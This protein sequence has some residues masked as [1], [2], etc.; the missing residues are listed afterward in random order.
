VL[1]AD[2]DWFE[3]AGFKAG[4]PLA[5]TQKDSKAETPPVD[6]ADTYALTRELPNKRRGGGWSV[7]L[8]RRGKKIVRLFKDSIYGSPEAAYTQARAYRDAVISALPPLTNLEQAVKIRKNNQSGISGVRRVETEEGDAWQATLMT[9][10][11]QKKET[12]S[13]GRLGEEAARS[14]AITQRTRWLKSLPIKH[15]AYARHAEEVTRQNFDRQ[16]DAVAD[17]APHVQISEEQVLAC[18]ADINARF[19][20]ERPPRLKV[21]IRNYGHVRLTLAVSDGGHPARR[22][23]VHINTAKMTHGGALA[24]VSMVQNLV[25]ELYNAEV[26]RW[27]A[28][29]HGNALL[30]PE[31][32]DPVIGFNVMVWVPN[33]LIA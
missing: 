7:A 15:L 19:D 32:F 27:F 10:E 25:E 13:I 1:R 26:A 14:L 17:V 9:N 21:R 20:R 4:R 3:G 11:G 22:R 30:A 8:R 16:R 23:L 6:D 18:I 24:A 2:R 12:F 29:E 33:E 31:N 5:S 28:R